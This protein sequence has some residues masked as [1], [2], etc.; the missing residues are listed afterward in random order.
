MGTTRTLTVVSTSSEAETLHA[1]ITMVPA[2]V[3]LTP[4]G[5]QQP[6]TFVWTFVF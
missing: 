2:G 4:V 1:V 3:T 5:G 6:G